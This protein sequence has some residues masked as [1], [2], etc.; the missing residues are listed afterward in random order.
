M[1]GE[2]EHR[3]EAIETWVAMLCSR[4]GAQL[5]AIAVEQKRGALVF[6]LNKYGQLHLYPI[7]PRA[8]AQ[9]RA[10]LFPSGVKD[11][12]VDADL[13]LELLV[14]H[15]RHL[16]RLS[17]DTEQTRLVQQLVEARRRMVNEQ[18]R[19]WNRLT[20][21][22]KIYFPQVLEWFD[23][24]DSPLVG[25]FLQRWPTLEAIQKARVPTL[26]S[27][28]A[29]HNYR[30]QELIDQRL[31][32]IRRAVP[33]IRDAAVIQSAVAMTDVLVQLIA[34]LVAGQHFD[35]VEGGD[36]AALDMA[37]AERLVALEPSIGSDQH[38]LQGVEVEAAEAVAR[39]VIP[40]GA[41]D[42]D[43]VLKVRLGQIGLQ[44]LKTGEPEEEGVENG[45]EH[46][47]GGISG[48]V[49][50]RSTAGS[51]RGSGRPC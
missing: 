6:M 3:P 7:H 36:D 38:S 25:A 18:T 15:R 48:S 41:L 37:L 11:D 49:G 50:R 1:R 24:V 39:H 30:R 23:E 20:A 13:L 46:A 12:P 35:A 16:R 5:I 9:F 51:R 47:L 34:T 19:Q 26:R 31:E 28:F 43:A 27:V 17:P 32:Q 4:F 42:A 10:A 29:R 14:H 21:K 8:A 44:L 22:L 33:A 45:E 2:I 40:K